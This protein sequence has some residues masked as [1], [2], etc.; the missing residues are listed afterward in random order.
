MPMSHVMGRGLLYSTLHV[1]GTA[2]FAARS[3]LSTFLEDLALVRPTRLSFVPRIWDMIFAEVQRELDRRPDDRAAVLSEAR[4]RLLG[5]RYV[6]AMTGSAPMSPEMRAFVEEL[7]DIHLVDGY[8]STEAGA[9]MVD[10]RLQRP[11]VV[12][13][14]LVDVPDLGYFRTDRPHPRGELLVKS[15]GLF[16][17]YYK[18]PEL[19]AEM[20]DDDGYYR[21]GDVVAETGPDQL[22]YLDRRNNVLKLSQGEFV[23]VSKLEA[24]FGDSPLVRQIYVYGNSA[25]SY[26]L[27]V[28]VPTDDALA[29][30]RRRRAQRRYRRIA[31]RCREGG[32]SAVLRD[33]AR[34]SD[35]DDPVHTRERHADR[36][37]QAGKAEAQGAVRRKPRAALRRAGRGPGRRVARIAAG[38]CRRARAADGHPRGGCLARC[39]CGRR[40]EPMRTSPISVVTRC[41]R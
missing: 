20:F 4:L 22:V 3:D 33:T 38:R 19:T 26:L 21:T 27:A 25:R 32:G 13:Y 6:T 24:A 2:Y 1:G 7:L 12:D 8:G 16:P 37:P 31:F 40:R 41:R 28:V 9:I 23:T 5:G 36:H 11:P 35:R 10:G 14:R 39:R 17:G 29:R 30:L 15:D 18:R 34:R